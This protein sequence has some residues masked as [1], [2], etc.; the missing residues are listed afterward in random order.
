MVSGVRGSVIIG[1]EIG[2]LT[3]VIGVV[4][5]DGEYSLFNAS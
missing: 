1:L 2:V 4:A 3:E 5:N